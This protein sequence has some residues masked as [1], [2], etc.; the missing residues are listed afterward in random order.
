ML[1]VYYANF[2]FL[3]AP[4]AESALELWKNRRESVR[5][6]GALQKF[7]ANNLV[8]A[9]MAFV[10][11]IPTLVTRQIIFGN[12]LGMGLYTQ[13]HWNWD[14]PAFWGILFSLKRGLAV[15]TPVLIP[16]IAGLFLL[17]RRDKQMGGIFLGVAAA[18]YALIAAYP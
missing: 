3:I 11:F 5:T 12:P 7:V 15:W 8:L 10:A 18:Y 14:H 6:I 2:V 9:A 4:L 13:E 16:A 1:D 17:P